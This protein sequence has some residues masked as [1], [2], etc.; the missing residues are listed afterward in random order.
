[1]RFLKRLING[2]KR[3]VLGMSGGVDSSVAAVL[4]K[5]QGYDVVGLFMKNWEDVDDSGQCSAA[6]DYKDVV[7]VCEEIGIPYYSVEFIKEY[8]QRVFDNFL[9]E[10]K[11]GRTP[12][13]DVLCNREIKF[14]VF[15]QEAKKLGAD[16]LAMGHYCQNPVVKGE[17]RLSKGR[18]PNKDQSYFLHAL[19]SSV[20]EKVLFPVGN[21]PKSRVRKIAKK[22]DLSTKDKK[23]STGICFIGERKFREFLSNYIPSKTGDFELLDGTVVGK[24]HGS[25]F[26]TLGQR[27]G[28]GL[29][30]PGEPWFVVA[31]NTDRNVVIVERGDR[32]PAL[33]C[34]Y[35]EA[36]EITWISENQSFGFPY[37]CKCKVRYRQQD[38]DCVIE[39]IEGDRMKVVFPIPQRAITP[40]Q[41]IVFY[42]GD[43]CLGGAVIDQLGPSYHQ[44]KKE[45]PELVS[46]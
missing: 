34:D 13:P 5:D 44:M 26:Y 12:N 46:K 6:A 22:Y 27:K 10:Y 7:S 36:N 8:R 41:S 1:M 33:Y 42:D 28:L 39:Y 14:D 2:K 11:K 23:D 38:Q 40:G 25:A 29:G 32:H 4:L 37:K 15:Y 43:I 3:V 18:D 21:I 45:L 24:H 20:L 9:E 31:K 16:Y 35:L 19:K 30:G 17:R